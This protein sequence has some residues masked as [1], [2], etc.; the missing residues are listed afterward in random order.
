MLLRSYQVVTIDV[1][2]FLAS[3]GV[4]VDVVVDTTT[5]GSATPDEDEEMTQPDD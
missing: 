3:K 5:A 1:D 4:P 2:E